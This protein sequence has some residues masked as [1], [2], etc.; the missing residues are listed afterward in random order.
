MYS[1]VIGWITIVSMSI[2][3]ICIII[4]IILY[5]LYS[6]SPNRQMFQ[7]S[8][9]LLLSHVTFLVG[10][11]LSFSYPACYAAGLLLH[12]AF[13]LSFSWVAAV[14]IDLIHR[15]CKAAKLQK[16]SNKKTPVTKLLL[17]F[18][19]PSL[20]LITSVAV[21]SKLPVEW[22]SQY[23][24]NICWFNSN[25]ALLIFFVAPVALY[26]LIT[27]LLTIVTAVK[28]WITMK[29]P[30]GKEKNK[31]VVFLK[32]SIITGSSWIFGFISDPSENTVL[33]I[34]FVILNASQGLFLLLLIWLPKLQKHL[35]STGK[36]RNTKGRTI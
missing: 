6:S 17:P 11:Q 21:E 30:D 12:W 28:L 16:T 15:V 7:L 1:P 9:C 19:M 8:C 14:A 29:D 33:F 22:R 34:L 5:F 2:S 24:T 25:N 4:Y 13:L 26:V 20:I 31:F 3:A 23:G 35:R 36:S 27:A 18:L 10:P 32:L